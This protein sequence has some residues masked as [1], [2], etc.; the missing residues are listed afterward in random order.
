MVLLTAVEEVLHFISHIGNT[1]MIRSVLMNVFILRIGFHIWKRVRLVIFQLWPDIR[2][3]CWVT[4]MNALV[5][6]SR[7]LLVVV[8]S[9]L[10]M[11]IVRGLRAVWSAYWVSWF[12]TMPRLYTSSPRWHGSTVRSLSNRCQHC[13]CTQIW[14]TQT[15]GMRHTAWRFLCLDL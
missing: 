4:P 1:D 10:A 14:S 7:V 5:V 6:V 13:W 3:P 8:T 11:S 12:L 15:R 2:S 9:F